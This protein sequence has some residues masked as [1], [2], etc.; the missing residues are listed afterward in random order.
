MV[1][2]RPSGSAEG[3]YDSCG[4]TGGAAWLILVIVS[5]GDESC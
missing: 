5:A 2:R 1:M 3:G 4:E